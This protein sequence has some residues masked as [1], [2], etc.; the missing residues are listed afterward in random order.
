MSCHFRCGIGSPFLELLVELAR[1]A[2]RLFETLTKIWEEC[3][4]N[5][6]LLLLVLPSIASHK[7]PPI[8]LTSC[9]S[10]KLV[11]RFDQYLMT[12]K[13]DKTFGAEIRPRNSTRSSVAYFC[14]E[15]GVHNSLPLYSGGLGMLAGD[16]L[17]SA[18]DVGIPL[19]LWACCIATL[20]HSAF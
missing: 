9:A 4:H 2:P 1:T 6:R 15:Y 8:L 19:V 7:W 3:E 16:H 12:V 20:F 17:K 10:E 14:A 5:P 18:S 13:H 11:E